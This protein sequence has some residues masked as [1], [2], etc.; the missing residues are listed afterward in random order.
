[1]ITHFHADHMGQINPSSP[2]SQDGDYRLSG[3]TEVDARWPIRCLID[4]AW[5]DYTYPAP[6]QDQTMANYQAKG[7]A[8]K[9]IAPLL[10]ALPAGARYR[11]L[12]M[13]RNLDEILASQ[14]RMIE[15][16][17]EVTHNTPER[18]ARLKAEYSRLVEG[19]KAMLRRRPEV[20]VLYLGSESVR[21]GPS[22]AAAAIDSFLGGRLAVD[23]MAAQ[24]RPELHRQQA[25]RQE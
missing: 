21:R 10:L 12:F 23:A 1:L 13:E 17:K 25:G 2:I 22:A 4:R 20:E 14:A 3:I 19:V 9:I 6:F 7:K 8:V 18:R 24:V 11:V 5:P 16:R 15:P